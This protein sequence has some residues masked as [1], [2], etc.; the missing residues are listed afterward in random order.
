MTELLPC[1]LRFLGDPPPPLFFHKRLEAQLAL[2]DRIASVP[3]D[4][5]EL[6]VGSGVSLRGWAHL[7][8]EHGPARRIWGFDTFAGFPSFAP[9]DGALDPALGKRVGALRRR[10]ARP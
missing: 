10:A 8:A 6:G 9:E 1:C 5:V 3:G 2:F 4:V 7:V